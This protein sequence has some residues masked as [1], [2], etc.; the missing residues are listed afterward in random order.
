MGFLVEETRS[1]PSKELPPGNLDIDVLVMGKRTGLSFAEINELR[2][3]DL[4]EFVGAYTGKRDDKPRKATQED[5]D[6]FFAG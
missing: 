3:R 5:I 6:K 1:K 4:I 2:V